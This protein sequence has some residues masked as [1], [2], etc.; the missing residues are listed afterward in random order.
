T[1]LPAVDEAIALFALCLLLMFYIQ[2][3]LMKWGLF[4][5]LAVSQ[6]ALFFGPAALFALL[7]KWKWRETFKLFPPSLRAV[8]GGVW[9]GVGLVPVVGLLNSLQRLVW[10]AD[11]EM[12]KY[13]N[14]LIVPVL[15][16]HPFI[17]PIFVG[18][19]AGVFEE[20]LFRGPIQTALMRKSR[21]WVAITVTAV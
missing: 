9:L 21:P 17:T 6:V 18:A 7:G 10:P 19:F 1:R 3:S 20:L 13:M 14:D 12:E 4:V 2:P 15:Q 16:S 11:S 5:T 8:A